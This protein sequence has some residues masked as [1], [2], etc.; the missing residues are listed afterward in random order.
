MP[1]SKALRAVT[2]GQGLAGAVLLG[3]PNKVATALTPEN[4][5]VPAA[6][7]VRLLGARMLAQGVVQGMRPQRQVVLTGAS[8]DFAHLLSMLATALLLP[9]YRRPA[10]VSAVSAALSTAAA[11]SSAAATATAAR[12]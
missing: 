10:L 1:E 12:A 4:G 5:T 2:V 3:W 11:A 9:R 6:W 7:L 8:L